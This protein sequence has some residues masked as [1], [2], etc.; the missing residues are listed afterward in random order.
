MNNINQLA[1]NPLF[2]ECGLADIFSRSPLGFI[3]VGAR[4]GAHELLE[5]I[6]K[7]TSVL[8]FEPDE[9]ECERLLSLREVTEPWAEFYLEASA[10]AEKE[11]IAELHLLSAATNHSL[12][13]PNL[14]ITDRY[15][16]EKWREIGRLELKTH[17]L[18]DVLS[19]KYSELANLGEFIKLDTQ[20]TEYE[21]LQG[22][23]KMLTER[24]VA[25]VVEVAF[26]EL[27]KGQ[28]L[29]SEVE[30]LLREFGF[31]FY[32]LSSSFNR[33]QRQLD[34][35]SYIS[36]ERMFYA[37]AVFFKD[38]LI[39]KNEQS[40]NDR[41][42]QVLTCCALLLGYFDFALELAQKTW[43]LKEVKD[44]QLAFVRLIKE[45]SFTDAGAAKQAVLNLAEQVNQEPDKAN[46]HI[47]GFVDK[48]R[49]N[50]DYHDVFNTLATPQ[51]KK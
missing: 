13:P 26:A 24:T 7:Y 23:Q 30:L 22:A 16:M 2:S 32:G 20:G 50:C 3:D 47:G 31:S 29:F 5:P 40:S 21:I 17:A 34:K 18:D 46:I 36:K 37:D 42:N 11:K 12:L 33:S 35:L 1:F 51:P 44:K 9:A 25:V 38:P 39:G 27:Y 45:L 6:A 4:G 8:A 14:D 43:L 15:N 41:A 28:K 49:G 19:N 10:L 48:R